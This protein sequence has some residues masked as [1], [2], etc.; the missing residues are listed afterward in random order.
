MK[1]LV[2]I[3][4]CFSCCSTRGTKQT[5]TAGTDAG[6]GTV[7]DAPAVNTNKPD[8]T[9]LVK[10]AFAGQQVAVHFGSIASGPIGDEFL[11][12][13]LLQF[14]REEKVAITAEKFSGCGKEG[15]YIIIINKNNFNKAIDEKFT[16]GLEKLVEDEVKRTKAINSS[17][18]SVNITNDPNIEEYSYCRLGSKKW[19]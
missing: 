6:N 4:V 10:P 11:K 17:S 12:T 9:E 5:S 7:T 18:G 14:I 19:L 13:W 2:I 3:F 15:E 1:Y 8:T 16:S